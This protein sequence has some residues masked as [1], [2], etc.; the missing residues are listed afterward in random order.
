MSMPQIILAHPVRTAIGSY[1][2]ALK[3]APVTELG[4]ITAG[5]EQHWRRDDRRGPD[6][7]RGERGRAAGP[8]C[9][10]FSGNALDDDDTDDGG[11]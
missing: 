8:S 11:P 3:G 1:N 4:A 9:R 6:F 2:G 7:C 10:V 5:N